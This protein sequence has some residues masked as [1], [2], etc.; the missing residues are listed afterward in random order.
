MKSLAI[1]SI[2]FSALFLTA[3]LASAHDADLTASAI[4]TGSHTAVEE[5]EGKA[6]WGKL[7]DKTLNCADL[8][9]EDFAMLGEYFMGAMLGQSHEAM[10]NMMIQTMG[11]K[12]EEDTHVAMARRLSGCDS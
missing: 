4:S 3:M 11:E 10:N 5:A 8:S 9:D 12:S 1:T 7:R 6:I 2:V